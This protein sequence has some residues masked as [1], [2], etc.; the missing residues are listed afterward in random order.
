[1]PNARERT[2]SEILIGL[3]H[4]LT[5]AISEYTEASVAGRA[6]RIKERDAVTRALVAIMEHLQAPAEAAEFKR[7]VDAARSPE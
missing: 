4:E 1:M 5:Y 6:P 2:K 3:C 7:R